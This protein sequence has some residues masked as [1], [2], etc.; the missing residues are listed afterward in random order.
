MANTKKYVSLDKLSLYD[1]KIKKLI[2]D[3]DAAAL[4]SA[5]AYADGLATNYDAAGSAASAE[6]AAKSYT[7]TEVA[8]ASAA[9]AAAQKAADDAAAAAGVADGKA[10]TAQSEVDALEALVGSLPEGTTATTVVEY[11]NKKTEGIATD[12][13]LGELNSQVSGLQ[14]AVQGIQS[15]YL[16]GE[17]KTE[18]EGKINAKAAQTDLDAVSAVANAAATQT[19]L[20]AEVKT[21]G[22]EITRIEGLITAETQR[23]TG[24]EADFETRIAEME[25]FWEAADDP[26]GTIDKLAEIVNYIAA[27]KTGA[28]D[29]AGDIE[30]NTKAIEDMD[31]A[32]KAADETLQGNID[33]KADASVVEAIDGRVGALETES[34]KHALK[35]EVQAVSDALTAYDDAHKGDYTNAQ[36]D[37]AIKVNTDAIAKLNDTYATDAELATAIESEVTR[38]NGAYAAKALETT[39]S[40]HVA[41]AVAH[42]TADD[43][44][45][46]N[47]ALQAADITTGAANGTIAVKGT[48]VLVK[49]LGSA[50]FTEASAYEVAGAAA[51][52]QGKLDEEIARA[53]AAEKV[54]AD[55]IAAFVEVSEDEINDLFKA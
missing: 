2:S 27:D 31:A 12:A 33:K 13:A 41:D 30:A 44:T 6:A 21:R 37:A 8:K 55:A 52:V 28:L 45:K 32:Y 17:D 1:T 35:T 38:A 23:A 53:K 42:V 11:V 3:A 46:W 54:N 10:V 29:M 48:D 7:D 26:E 34:A 51:T 5:K 16:K 39:V 20:E 40:T 49:G 50:A 19:A 14:T 36:I 25:T 43:K 47:A 4:A 15:D 9:A 24:V 22:E 18:L